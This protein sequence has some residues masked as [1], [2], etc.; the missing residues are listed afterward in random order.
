MPFC[1]KIGNFIAI[2]VSLHCGLLH[3]EHKDGAILTFIENPKESYACQG[4]L[5]ILNWVLKADHF[6]NTFE[7]YAQFFTLA[8]RDQI[9][10]SCFKCSFTSFWPK[11]VIRLIIRSFIWGKPHTIIRS[12]VNLQFEIKKPSK[13]QEKSDSE[14]SSRKKLKL[15]TIVHFK[16]AFLLYVEILTSDKM[17]LVDTSVFWRP[18]FRLKIFTKLLNVST[19]QNFLKFNFHPGRRIQ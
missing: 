5:D 7:S 8:N 18:N 10:F 17:T 14:Y 15:N 4:L 11:F 2:V 1:T 12:S 19:Y 3:L 13:F 6:K 9:V 16:P